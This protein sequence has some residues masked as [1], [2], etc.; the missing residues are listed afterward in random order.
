MV[1]RASPTKTAPS[2]LGAVVLQMLEARI[3]KQDR[4][5]GIGVFR[6]A[7]FGN[8]LGQQLLKIFESL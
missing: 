8:P 7:Y 3:G 5:V 1:S 6:L 4:S 2:E